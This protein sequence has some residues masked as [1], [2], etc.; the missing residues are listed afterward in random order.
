MAES[1]PWPDKHK[2]VRF[3]DMAGPVCEGIRFAYDLSRKNHHCSIPWNGYQI[4][5]Q[6]LA[7]CR[8]PHEALEI[9]QLHYDE[10]EQ[11]RDALEVLVGIAIQLGIEQGRRMEY[12]RNRHSRDLAATLAQIVLEANR[13]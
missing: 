4:G 1:K 8:D 13:D 3:C 9:E 11:G 5:Q 7:C 12:E 6:D 2:L 10:Q